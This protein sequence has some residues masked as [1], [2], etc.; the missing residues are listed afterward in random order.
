MLYSFAVAIVGYVIVTLT[1]PV[2]HVVG[3][4]DID[5][6]SGGVLFKINELLLLTTV[7][8]ALSLA[9]IHK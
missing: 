1:F 4:T 9:F 8:P 2:V 5:G 6:L 3:E 7:L